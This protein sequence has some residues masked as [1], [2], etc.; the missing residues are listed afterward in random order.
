MVRRDVQDAGMSNDPI[1]HYERGLE[2]GTNNPWHTGADQ[3]PSARRDSRIVATYIPMTPIIIHPDK[4][5]TADKFSYLSENE[6][7]LRSLFMT[8]QGEMPLA[9]QP[10][11]F[12]R[13]AGCNFGEKD[14][15]CQFCDTDFEVASS[16]HVETTVVEQLA[17]KAWREKIEGPIQVWRDSKLAV[18]TG[19]EPTIQPG[20]LKLVTH[21]LKMD[22]RV[23]IETN[24]TQTSVL[25]Q[26]YVK[27]RYHPN[28]YV[29]ASP[30]SSYKIPE[31]RKP[32]S[33]KPCQMFFEHHQSYLRFVLSSDPKHPHHEVPDWVLEDK[34][35]AIF[36][37]VYVSPMT[38]YNQSYDGEVS[39]IWADD[40]IDKEATRENYKYAAQYALMHG[41]NLSI[42]THT[43]VELA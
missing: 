34:T 20:F 25:E 42:Q 39:S 4:A 31:G 17:E 7:L 1:T 19:G 27:H 43:L 37:K 22:W 33:H 18:I 23:Q 29:V 38:V 13:L 14:A 2:L 6:I 9:G 26:M 32:V 5:M 3:T 35:L 16:N 40:L 10:A 36:G 12:I 24:G 21:L 15:F 8:L 30:K 28:L 41:F 11:V